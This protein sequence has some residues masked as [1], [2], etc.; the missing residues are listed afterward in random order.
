MGVHE[1]IDS[2]S[3]ECRLEIKEPDE[4]TAGMYKCLVSN[5]KGEINA[6]LMLNIQLAQREVSTT[7][8]KTTAIRKTSIESKTAMSVKKERRRSVILQCAVSGQSDVDIVWKKEGKQLETT[9]QRKTSRYSVEKKMS[10][11]NQTIIQLEIMDADVE[12]KMHDIV[13]VYELVAKNQEGEEQSQIVEL[14]EEQVKLS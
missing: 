1:K 7:D 13:G 12:D 2:T 5:E 3:Y 8:S 14:T 11:Q 4:K 10:T 6:N 9:D